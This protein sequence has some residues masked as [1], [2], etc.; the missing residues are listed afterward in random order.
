MSSIQDEIDRRMSLWKL[1]SSKPVG[2]IN[3]QKNLYDK[4]IMRGERG[5]YRNI[6]QTK[7]IIP[8]HCGITVAIRHTAGKY[9]DKIT[10]ENMIYSYPITMRKNH[11]L[12]EI[13]A[14]KTCINNNIPISII[15]DGID[16]KHKEVKLAWVVNSDD[17]N[18]KFLLEFSPPSSTTSVP[19][20]PSTTRAPFKLTGK[21]GTKIKSTVSIRPE[22]NKFRFEVLKRYGKKCGVCKSISEEV[23]QAA[24]VRPKSKRGSD[25]DRNGICLCANHHIAFD[26]GLFSIDPTTLEIVKKSKN[27]KIEETKLT[28]ATGKIPHLD[29]L[30]WKWKNP[31]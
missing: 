27:L 19:I 22:Q 14:T 7:L 10:A 31:K 16:S 28:T 3:F 4:K 25:D 5:I 30:E 23:I 21:A 1:F 13:E 9:D 11:D 20:K 12:G 15:L 17:L 26:K 24:H 18:K 8:N 2:H 29:A 6:N